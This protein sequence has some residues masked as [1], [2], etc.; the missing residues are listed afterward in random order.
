MGKGGCLNAQIEA[1]K[2]AGYSGKD[3]TSNEITPSFLATKNTIDECW[4]AYEGGIYDVTHWLRKHPGGIRSIMSVAG[5]DAS[6]VMKSLHAPS[7]LKT[8]MKRIRKIGN[9]IQEPEIHVRNEQGVC[10]SK[11]Q[12]QLQKK[13]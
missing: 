3:G 4:I 8:Y 7:T 1:T 6:S 9:L 10:K 2:L 12:L 13:R 5:Q 11:H